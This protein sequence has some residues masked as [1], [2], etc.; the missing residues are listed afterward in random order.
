MYAVYHGE[1]ARSADGSAISAF[2]ITPSHYRTTSRPSIL[3]FYAGGD[4]HPAR[5]DQAYKRQ[6]LASVVEVCVQ[7][8]AALAPATVK[9]GSSMVYN[10]GA[11]RRARLDDGSIM[12]FMG[13]GTDGRYETV[14]GGWRGRTPPQG[15]RVVETGVIDPEQVTLRRK[16]RML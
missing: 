7:A 13:G 14:A 10:V 5:V 2:I 9:V 12:H 16:S 3:S 8:H 1:H 6:T 4:I 15:R 11:N